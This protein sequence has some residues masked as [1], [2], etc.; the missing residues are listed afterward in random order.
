MVFFS[1]Y[2]ENLKRMVI[3]LGP[4]EYEERSMVNSASTPLA[5]WR[6]LIKEADLAVLKAKRQQEPRTGEKWRLRF[7]V[8]MLDFHHLQSA[9]SRYLK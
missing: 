9:Y 3:P 2:V 1:Y 8:T 4:E 7:M 5:M 6:K